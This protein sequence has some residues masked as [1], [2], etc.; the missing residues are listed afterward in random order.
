M[1]LKNIDATFNVIFIFLLDLTS[2]I[3]VIRN[4]WQYPTEEDFSGV[5]LGLER[6][7]RFYKLQTSD[8]ANG[9]IRNVKFLRSKMSASDC[10]HMGVEL[11]K[12]QKYY[13]AEQWF[14]EALSRTNSNKAV[15]LNILNYL[16]ECYAEQG[17]FL[18]MKR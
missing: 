18:H 13:Y 11:F 16:V 9:Q 10:Y 6:L 5:V 17:E 3:K 7:Q 1:Y 12:K 8:L 4:N 14:N 2:N 15:T